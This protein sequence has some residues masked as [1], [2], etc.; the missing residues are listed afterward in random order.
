M[1]GFHYSTTK[2]QVNSW[3][4]HLIAGENAVSGRTNVIT[5]YISNSFRYAEKVK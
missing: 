4:Q 5:I 1:V 2:L 3:D